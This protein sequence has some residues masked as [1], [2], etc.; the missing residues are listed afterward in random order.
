M[1][2]RRE[3]RSERSRGAQTDRI[4]ARGRSASGGSKL[5]PPEQDSVR[6]KDVGLGKKRSAAAQRLAETP[7]AEVEEIIRLRKN[8]SRFHF[9]ANHP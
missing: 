4:P 8:A 5:V 6:L 3:H 2:T 7:D 9:L 1:S